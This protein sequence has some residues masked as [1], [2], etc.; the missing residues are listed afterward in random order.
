M[1]SPTLYKVVL[2]GAGNSGKTAFIHRHLTGEF[3]Q[4]V[5]AVTVAIDCKANSPAKDGS[6]VRRMGF[7]AEDLQQAVGAE[8]KGKTQAERVYQID[9]DIYESNVPYPGLFVHT[10]GII[11]FLE[12]EKTDLEGMTK[13]IASL[14]R[15]P[16]VVCRSKCDVPR[17]KELR[18]EHQTEIQALLRAFPGRFHYY[19]LSSKSNYNFEKPFLYLLRKIQGSEALQF[20]EL[21]ADPMLPE[22]LDAEEQD[23][24]QDAL[25]K[26]A[27]T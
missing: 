14:P 10:S 2:L 22:E 23:T 27:S 24:K 1:S 12:P 6:V 4:G 7:M 17:S 9:L 15:V 20:A 3:Y 16:L 18:K 25:V 5:K 19:D 11:L 21:F 26:A 8:A 13:L